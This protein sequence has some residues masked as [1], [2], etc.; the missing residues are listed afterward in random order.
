M[1]SLVAPDELGPARETPA[2]DLEINP[3]GQHG[4]I[5][6]FDLCAALA[7]IAH[8]AVK[9]RVAGVERDHSAVIDAVSLVST[10]L[11]HASSPFD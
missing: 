8:D 1:T 10:A 2:L 11:Q 4:R 9:R 5:L 6:K 7:E 3:V